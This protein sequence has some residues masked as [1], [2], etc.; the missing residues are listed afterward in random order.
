VDCSNRRSINFVHSRNI[1][2]LF[3]SFLR[4]FVG[5]TCNGIFLHQRPKLLFAILYKCE[6]RLKLSFSLD[7]VF[8][9]RRYRRYCCCCCCSCH[10]FVVGGGVI[11]IVLLLLLMLKL[12]L[13][14]SLLSKFPLSLFLFCCCQFCLYH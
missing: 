5:S 6:R 12:M 14:L 9:K 1:V 10:C 8:C 4:S 11:V 7:D 13:V 3:P 2:Y